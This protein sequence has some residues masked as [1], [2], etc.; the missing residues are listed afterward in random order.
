MIIEQNEREYLTELQQVYETEMK[1]LLDKG[2]SFTK[3]IRRLGV[4]SGRH[5]RKY[6]ELKKLALADGYQMRR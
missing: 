1:P 3:V 2:Y 6:H 5:N 4:G